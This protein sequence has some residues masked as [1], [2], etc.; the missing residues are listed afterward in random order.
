MVKH[1]YLMTMK[2]GT[3]WKVRSFSDGLMT[4]NGD[5]YEIFFFDERDK[6]RCV[7]QNDVVSVVDKNGK[8][9][10][11]FGNKNIGKHPYAKEEV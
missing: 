4:L 1:K 9:Y 7:K 6:K 10:E 5:N 3:E 11:K 8:Q 2:D